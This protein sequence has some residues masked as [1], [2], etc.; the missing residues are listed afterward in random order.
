LDRFVEGSQNS[1]D[2]KNGVFMDLR[3]EVADG[4]V[5]VNSNVKSLRS[6]NT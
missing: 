1:R 6:L 4:L 3:L 2:M 5:A